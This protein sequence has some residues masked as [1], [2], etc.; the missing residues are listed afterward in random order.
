MKVKLT[1]VFIDNEGACIDGRNFWLSVGS[2]EDPA[3]AFM[4]ATNATRF[5]YCDWLLMS[6]VKGARDNV[7]MAVFVVKELLPIYAKDHPADVVELCE[8]VVKEMEEW[9]AD[10]DGCQVDFLARMRQCN[11]EYFRD[12]TDQDELLKLLD[13]ACWTI[14]M[15][16]ADPQEECLEQSYPAFHPFLTEVADGGIDA[17]SQALLERIT[18]KLAEINGREEQNRREVTE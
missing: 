9:L 10:P 3:K 14:H 13:N 16:R 18:A 2:P 8:A 11:V 15:H 4:E 7:E 5:G 1:R 6:C 17:G 12:C